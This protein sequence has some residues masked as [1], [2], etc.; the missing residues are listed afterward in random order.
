MTGELLLASCYCSHSRFEEFFFPMPDEEPDGIWKPNKAQHPS[1][2]EHIQVAVHH[3]P[4][5]EM[6]AMATID[7]DDLNCLVG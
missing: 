5:Q 2:P 1:V 4:M 7:M 6:V 3:G